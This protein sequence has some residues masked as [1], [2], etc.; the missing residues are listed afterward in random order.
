[1]EELINIKKE[2]KD[3]K[4]FNSVS[5]AVCLELIERCEKAEAKLAEMEKQEP[6]AWLSKCKTN[7]LVEITEP[8]QKATNPEHWTDAF[9]VHRLPV[10]QH[11]DELKRLA[12]LYIDAN[13]WDGEDRIG[14]KFDKAVFH[15]DDLQE[16]VFDLLDS[17]ALPP[18]T[19]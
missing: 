7:G 9:P 11:L 18:I 6:I 3:N 13:I 5:R 10:P 17:L 16:F 19:K 1:M 2:I 8:N 15:P 14:A 12:K 4:F